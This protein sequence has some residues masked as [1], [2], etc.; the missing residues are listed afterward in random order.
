VTNLWLLVLGYAAGSGVE[1]TRHH[2]AEAVRDRRQ[3]TTSAPTEP[4]PEDAE[5]ASP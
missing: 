2:I 4:E 3:R 1:I 5:C